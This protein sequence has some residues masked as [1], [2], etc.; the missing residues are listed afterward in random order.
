M[1]QQTEDMYETRIE[2]RTEI[3]STSW[4]AYFDECQESSS[5]QLEEEKL[6]VQV[7]ARVVKSYSSSSSSS[8]YSTVFID[9]T[10]VLARLSG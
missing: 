9:Y 1:L 10:I 7:C 3:I 5:L 4:K 6:K 2:Q 8:M